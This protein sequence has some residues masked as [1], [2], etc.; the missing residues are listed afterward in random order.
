MPVNGTKGFFYSGGA[1]RQVTLDPHPSKEKKKKK[2]GSVFVKTSLF[3]I[4][5]WVHT[6]VNAAYLN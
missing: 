1:H 2:K 4:M 3:L 6:K 5:H